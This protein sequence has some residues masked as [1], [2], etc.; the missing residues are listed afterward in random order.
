MEDDVPWSD[1]VWSRHDSSR[2]KWARV[3]RMRTSE[4]WVGERDGWNEGL[5]GG[6]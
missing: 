4:G 3:G 1:G 2:S 6:S 5:D